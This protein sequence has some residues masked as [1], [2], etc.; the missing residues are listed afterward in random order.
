[1]EMLAMRIITDKM[2]QNFKNY[3]TEEEKSKATIEKYIR[4]IT[5]LQNWSKECCIEKAVILE[6]KEII[7]GKYATRSV[8]SIIS[9]INSFFDF[10]AWEDCK[11]KLL[12]VQKQ[13]FA[14]ESKELKKEECERLL[15]AALD[16]KNERLYYLMQTI[17]STGIRVSEL[18]FITVEAVGLRQAKINCKGK[19]R[20]V[21]LSGSICK[22]LRKYI[23]KN[24]II[25]GSVFITKN[26]KPLDRSNIWADMKKLCELAD[27]AKEKVFP[28]NL[29]HL[30]ART[31]YSID[32]DIAHLADI[33]GHTSV[34]TTR[35]YIMETGET[36]RRQIEKM[37]L[38][39]C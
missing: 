37:H 14:D 32:K 33:L 36:H 18:K 19:E 4:D 8:N 1:M 35:I 24:K 2:I 11:V 13:I 9:S 15:K 7:K 39:R 16:S 10:V 29:R 17:C 34:N 25:S 27:V 31:F 26:G 20:V 30:F 5:A 22:L 28:H 3:L 21:I 12:K 6:Y 38:L 23:K